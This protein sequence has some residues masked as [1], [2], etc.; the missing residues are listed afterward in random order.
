MREKNDPWFTEF[1]IVG[2]VANITDPHKVTGIDDGA[3]IKIRTTCNMNNNEFYV[4]P[5]VKMRG[6]I[7]QLIEHP[8][9]Q[10]NKNQYNENFETESSYMNY[11]NNIIMYIICI[12]VILLLGFKIFDRKK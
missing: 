6:E 10:K 2:S 4:Y 5:C 11:V 8:Q 9:S 12:I 3:P 1:D 7:D